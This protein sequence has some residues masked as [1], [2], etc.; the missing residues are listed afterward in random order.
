MAEHQAFEEMLPIFRKSRMPQFGAEKYGAS[1]QEAPGCPN[2]RRHE[3]CCGA[4][5]WATLSKPRTP[6]FLGMQA[7]N[8]SSNKGGGPQARRCEFCGRPKNDGVRGK[9]AKPAAALR[10]PKYGPAARRFRTQKRP[11]AP[12]Y[13]G[14]KTQ[15]RPSNL[16]RA[17]SKT[18]IGSSSPNCTFSAARRT[19]RALASVSCHSFSGSESATMPAAACTYSMPFFTMPVRIAMAT[20]ISPL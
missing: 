17:W 19:A 4:I 18:Q 16:Q 1:N 6:S 15:K 7:R 12:Q 11:S 10:R 20:S 14:F 2:S 8:C 3:A 5:F 9:P 13:A